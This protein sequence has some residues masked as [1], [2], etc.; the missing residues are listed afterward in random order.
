MRTNESYLFQ[1]GLIRQEYLR[2]V[3]RVLIVLG[4]ALNSHFIWLMQKISILTLS[5]LDLSLIH[6]VVNLESLERKFVKADS[7]MSAGSTSAKFKFHVS[8]HAHF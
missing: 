8:V 5:V 7:K 6:K 1:E 4:K 3:Y 2:L